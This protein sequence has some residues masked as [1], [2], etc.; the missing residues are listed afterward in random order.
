MSL[1]TTKP[2]DVKTAYPISKLIK[3]HSY[4]CVYIQ[5]AAAARAKTE[6]DSLVVN[7]KSSSSL[8][9]ISQVPFDCASGPYYRYYYV[10]GYFYWPPIKYRTCKGLVCSRYAKCVGSKMQKKFQWTNMFKCTSSYCYFIGVKFIQYVEYLQCK[11]NYP[12][13]AIQRPQS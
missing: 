13:I 4:K 5:I 11:C 2:A 3:C 7:S 8:G 6:Y 10:P 1:K 12:T 9:M